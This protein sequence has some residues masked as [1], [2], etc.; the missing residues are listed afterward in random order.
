MNQILSTENINDKSN[1][2][3]GGPKS[4]KSIV[5]FFAIILIIFGLF[6]ITNSS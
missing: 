3:K 2:Q 4:I 5:K 1:K 6:L